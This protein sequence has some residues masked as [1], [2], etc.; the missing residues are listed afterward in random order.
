VEFP[1][2]LP[3]ANDVTPLRGC[4]SWGV[5]LGGPGGLRAAR[6]NTDG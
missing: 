3:P 1:G 6:L 5:E 2:A 4:G